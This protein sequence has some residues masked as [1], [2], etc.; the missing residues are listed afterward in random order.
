MCN[1]RPDFCYEIGMVSRFMNKSKWSHYKVVIRIMR[2]IKWNLRYV[3]LFAF[4]VRIDSELIC[5]SDSNWHGDKV[6][7]RSTSRYFFKYLGSLI[8]W[9]SKKQLVVALSTCKAKYNGGALTMCQVVWLTNFLQDLEI[10]VS[11][12]VKLI[13][14]LKKSAISLIKNLVMHERSK[15]INTKFHFLRSQVQN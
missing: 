15:H 8:S 9:C 6:D 13:F 12:L 11:K 2:Y 5:Y 4:G 10:K 3:V 1:A 14:D 7:K